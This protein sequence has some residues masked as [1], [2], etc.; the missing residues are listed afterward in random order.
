MSKSHDGGTDVFERRPSRDDSHVFERRT[1]GLMRDVERL[2]Q[3]LKD[4][5]TR[6]MRHI[7][8]QIDSI[9][10]KSEMTSAQNETR[11]NNVTS[12]FYDL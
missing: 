4:D 11:F 7:Q 10:T 2:V 5:V 12:Q 1:D 8:Q 6:E 9:K 3:K